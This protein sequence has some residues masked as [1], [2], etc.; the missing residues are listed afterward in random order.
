MSFNKVGVNRDKQTD[1]FHNKLNLANDLIC[2]SGG[3]FS[4]RYRRYFL[5]L[6]SNIHYILMEPK[7][8]QLRFSQ[9]TKQGIETIKMRLIVYIT[10]QTLAVFLPLERTLFFNLTFKQKSRQ[11]SESGSFYI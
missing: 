8:K 5:F 1:L 10:S 7:L 11:M 3:G 2:N 4:Q 6:T 9:L